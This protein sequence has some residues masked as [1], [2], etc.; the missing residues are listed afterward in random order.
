MSVE[1]IPLTGGNVSE[2][3]VRVGDTVRRPCGYWTPAVH[4]L[5]A[6]LHDVGFSGAPKPLGIDDQG[7]E[8]LSFAAGAAVYPGNLGLISSDGQL[9][10]VARLIREFHSA[11][12]GFVAPPDARWQT[13][14]PDV[15]A[16]LIVHHDLAPWN[17]VA[18][19]GNWTFIDWDAAAPGTR[20]WD[21]AYSLHSFVPLTAN[22]ASRSEDDGHRIRV[23]ADA[24][25]LDEPERRTLASLLAP[26]ARSMHDFLQAQAALSVQPWTRLWNE[27]HGDNWRDDADYIAQHVDGWTELLLR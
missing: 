16:D 14:I 1:E 6:Y 12:A 11:V 21:V 8:V 4:A 17:L 7:R 19:E 5:L 22:P 2:G 23:F 13:L 27:G 18:G 20:L 26:R 24:Y 3:V 9:A 25:G 10:R 15:G